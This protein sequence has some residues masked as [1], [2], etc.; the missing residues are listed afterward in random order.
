MNV[1]RP[2]ILFFIA[3]VSGVVITYKNFS[4]VDKYIF[5]SA[6]VFFILFLFLNK[7]IKYKIFILLTVFFVFGSVRFELEKKYFDDIDKKIEMLNNKKQDVVGVVKK[8]GKSTNSNYV[9]FL[10][11]TL[12]QLIII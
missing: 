1:K 9:I 4:V 12:I 5:L 7:K 6:T 2:I 3:F 8:I 11:C 10:I